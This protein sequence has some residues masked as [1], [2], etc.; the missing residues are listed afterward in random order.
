MS[1]SPRFFSFYK[2]A[3]FRRGTFYHLE[4]LKAGFTIRRE[5]VYRLLR[6]LRFANPLLSGAILDTAVDPNGRWFLLDEQQVIWRA[7]L[8]SGH[9]ET[10][11]RCANLAG[12]G[13][14]LRIAASRDSVFV[15]NAGPAASIQ[16]LTADGGQVRWT[17]SDWYGE[18]IWGLALAAEPDDGVAVL[19]GI[20]SPENVQLLRLD[21][22]GMPRGQIAMPF[23]AEVKADET[24]ADRFQFSIGA[25]GSGWILDRK[26]GM[27]A[28]VQPEAGQ[29]GIVPYSPDRLADSPD[30]EEDETIQAICSDGGDGAWVLSQSGGELRQISL[31][32]VRPD[33]TSGERGHAGSAEGGFMIADAGRILIWNAG[34][35]ELFIVKPVSETAVWKPFGRRMGI[36]LSDALDSGTSGTEWHKLVLNAER[37]HDTQIIVRYYASDQKQVIIGHERVD[38]SEYI[39]NPDIPPER[40]LEALAGIWSEPLKDPQ[41]ALFIKAVGRYLWLN[42]ELIGSEQNAPRVHSME[43]H[44]PRSS[45]M[46]Y[47]PAIYQRHEPSRDFLSR[48]LSLFQ[49]L[50]DETERNIAGATRTFDAGGVSG[51]S[52]RWLLGWLGIRA[53]DQW[54]EEQ[55]RKLLRKAPEIYRLRGTRY[56]LEQLIEIYTGEKPIILEYEQVKP[57]KENPELSEVTDQLYASEPHAFNVLVKAEHADTEVKRATLR[58]I[59]EAFKPVFASYKLIILQPWVYMDFHSYLGMNTVLSE[60]DLARLDG[61]S[62][63]PHHTITIDAGLENRLD[64]HSRLG[65]DS[66]LE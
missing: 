18:A 44:F 36:W 16:S 45:L 8:M 54:T 14:R 50:L 47:L 15:M 25:K 66:R 11:A 28:H 58:Q 21:A 53:E 12:E 1:G 49:T 20:G 52:L 7:D 9:A 3:D 42:I 40:K 65:L 38:L 37:E 55:L 61:R 41:D 4:S 48:F 23:F 29:A 35:R 33:G 63:M 24:D 27:L 43:V 22:S 13:G 31:V 46:E 10:A 17:V 56:A 59:I 39:R 60:P 26:S 19:A 64:Q 34:E 57:L 51:P 32:R 5:Q 6:R 62:S 30:D 2:P